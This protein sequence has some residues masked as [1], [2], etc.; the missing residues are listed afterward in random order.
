MPMRQLLL[1]ALLACAVPVYADV[2]RCVGPDGA[3]TF[4]QTPCSD[5]AEKVAVSSRPA[6]KG[7]ADCAFA[8]HFARSTSQLMRQR[9]D[10]GRLIKQFGGPEAF[11]DGATRIVNYVYQYEST[12]SIS[13]DR[14][15]EL[16]VAQCKAGAFGG[17]TCETLPKPYTEAGGGCDGSFSAT[18]ARFSVDVF[19]I[20]QDQAAERREAQHELQR[21]Q[22]A[23]L[24]KH[25]AELG[26]GTQCRQEIEAKIAQIDASIGFGADPNGYRSELKR[27]RAQLGK[28]GPAVSQ[29]PV[30]AQPGG[31]HR[32]RKGIE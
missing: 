12:Q 19:A 18:R 15:A 2:Y 22:S 11:D 3:T 1:L 31:Y 10:K 29:P 26:R 23:E 9:V 21:Q 6:A 32:I 4:S 20:H 5:S 8:E 30:Q 13:H 7:T 17:V 14:I 24:S 25:Y 16:A 28:C 27:L